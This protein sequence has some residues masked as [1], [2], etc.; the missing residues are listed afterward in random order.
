MYNYCIDIV[1]INIMKNATCYLS[2]L[3]KTIIIISIDS[4]CNRLRM[5]FKRDLVFF[6][7]FNWNYFILI[8]HVMK[9]P[10]IRFGEVW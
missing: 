6:L 5:L 9:S 8:I 2:A 3:I 10:S 7:L 4:I 1:I